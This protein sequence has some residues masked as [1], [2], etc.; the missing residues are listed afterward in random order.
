MGS[1]KV[2]RKIVERVGWSMIFGSKMMS[3]KEQNLKIEKRTDFAL[4][5]RQGKFS[6][7]QK[8]W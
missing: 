5:L 6:K 3:R 8:V 7:Y 2:V 1:E 4:V